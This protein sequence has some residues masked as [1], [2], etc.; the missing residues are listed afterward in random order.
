MMRKVG[1]G[2]AQRAAAVG[3]ARCSC[4]PAR[5]G[6]ARLGFGLPGGGWHGSL[7]ARGRLRGC[8]DFLP[9]AEG[10]G[11]VPFLFQH[12]EDLGLSQ[13]PSHPRRGPSCPP[14]PTPISLQHPCA[15]QVPVHPLFF[16]GGGGVQPPMGTKGF[17]RCHHFCW[18]SLGE[19]QVASGS[20][21]SSRLCSPPYEALPPAANPSLCRLAFFLSSFVGFFFLPL[22]HTFF[23]FSFS[24]PKDFFPH[25]DSFTLKLFQILQGHVLD[26]D[27]I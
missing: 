18:S 22:S 15:V 17:G 9:A 4:C 24:F 6:S 8:P 13:S 19:V 12:R 14:L 2:G 23:I 20:A 27:M 26:A 16:G 1:G 25:W 7:L 5:L 21:T 3:G 10:I 11:A